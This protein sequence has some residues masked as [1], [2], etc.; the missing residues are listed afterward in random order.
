MFHEADVNKDGHLTFMEWYE[1]LGSASTPETPLG[2]PPVEIPPPVEVQGEPA[3]S[4]VS[5]AESNPVSTST[6][7][8][9]IT[10]LS[11]VLGNAVCT[12]KTAARISQDPS[13]LSAAFI[14]GGMM[15]GVLDAQ[16]CRTMLSR[17][18]PATRYA[19]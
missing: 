19:K 3:S 2:S 17:L 14:S 13:A 5:I 8:P 7:D 11:L 10:A 6:M 18:S 4:A 16:V 12:L 9:M 1:W 15:A